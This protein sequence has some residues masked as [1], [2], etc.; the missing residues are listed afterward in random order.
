M[1]VKICGSPQRDDAGRLSEH[2][3]GDEP[4]ADSDEEQRD[5]ADCLGQD[6]LGAH[7]PCHGQLEQEERYQYLLRHLP[8][9]L[10]AS[11]QTRSLD[12]RLKKVQ[13][14]LICI[15]LIVRCLIVGPRCMTGTPVSRHLLLHA[16]S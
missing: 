10:Q 2:R 3:V 5:D 4:G 1:T 12:L 8:P 6:T 14:K 11:V 15:S 16:A 7:K 9:H 13:Y